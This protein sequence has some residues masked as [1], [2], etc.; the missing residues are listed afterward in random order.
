MSGPEADA[1][2]AAYSATPLRRGLR[3]QLT[4]MAVALIAFTT[5][6]TGSV[7]VSANLRN[8]QESAERTA[9][10]LAEAFAKAADFGLYTQNPSELAKAASI[11]DDTAIVAGVEIYNG[12]NRRIYRELFQKVSPE[13]LEAAAD[14]GD[15]IQMSPFGTVPVYRISIPV[16]AS[17]DLPAVGARPQPNRLLG[18]VDTIIDL[19]SVQR[20]FQ[21]SALYIVGCSV[22]IGLFAC[23]LAWSVSG[24][25]LRPVRD[26]LAGLRDVSEGN[27]S[28]KLP[29]ADSSEL[30]ALITGFNQMI[31]GLRHYRS[32]TVRAREVLEQRVAVRTDALQ[33]EKER[34]EAASK[35]KSEFLARMSHEIRTPMNGALSFRVLL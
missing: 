26:V 14:N 8:A 18:T 29:S 25:I 17:S 33:R 23:V 2:P 32:E 9:T 19:S 12:D 1:A 28:H 4:A 7:T 3:A 20:R 24:R 22:L 15:G 30:G 6:V 11:V 13:R 27:F 31:D 35:T 34:A 10:V 21:L 16:Y 5:L